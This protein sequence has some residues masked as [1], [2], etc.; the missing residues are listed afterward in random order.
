[1][2]DIILLNYGLDSINDLVPI[3]DNSR[4]PLIK[5]QFGNPLIYV[6][7]ISSS[8][9]HLVKLLKSVSNEATQL[10]E[11]VEQLMDHLLSEKG[12]YGNIKDA[13]TGKLGAGMDTESAKTLWDQCFLNKAKGPRTKSHWVRSLF[14]KTASLVSKLGRETV[15]CRL[16]ESEDDL[17]NKR[18]VKRIS[19]ELIDYDLFVISGAFLIDEGHL[20]EVLNIILT[21][22]KR[23]FPWLPETVNPSYLYTVKRLEVPMTT[24]NPAP[25]MKMFPQNPWITLAC[26]IRN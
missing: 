19:I 3:L 20:A 23:Y 14:P 22:Y 2:E 12:I 15:K 5:D 6:E 8:T 11:E 16:A 9:F 4:W 7:I 18:I 21:E 26:T 1:V 10:N 17:I 13:H 25:R 24:A